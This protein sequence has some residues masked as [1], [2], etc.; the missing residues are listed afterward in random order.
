MPKTSDEKLIKAA[1]EDDTDAKETLIERIKSIALPTIKKNCNQTSN[2][3]VTALMGEIE[4]KVLNALPNY[5]FK[6]S[7]ETWI[8]RI[9]MNMILE[10][11]KR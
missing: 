6:V 2:E 10:Y 3:T 4:E 9:T 11:Q 1:I 5:V 7:F 8:Y